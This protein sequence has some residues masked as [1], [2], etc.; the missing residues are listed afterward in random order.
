MTPTRC[1]S[2]TTLNRGHVLGI[3][4]ILDYAGR[5]GMR[6]PKI[7]FADLRLGPIARETPVAFFTRE[8]A[9]RIIAEAK[10]PFKTLFAPAWM[11]W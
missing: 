7:R 5:C 4:T 1:E 11:K 6:V 10:E 8:Q 3:S 2:N 9:T